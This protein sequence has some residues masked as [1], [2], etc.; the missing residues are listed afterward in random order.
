M[1]L[2]SLSY[3]LIALVLAGCASSG[4]SAAKPVPPSAAT[5]NDAQIR[6]ALVGNKLTNV[7]KPSSLSFNADGT[8]NFSG[9][10]GYSATER[11]E[12]KDGVLCISATGFATECH[13]VKAENKDFWFID[14]RSG[15]VKYQYKLTAQ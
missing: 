5:L 13:R 7:N 15:E 14:P 10:D 1:N 8:E 4:G 9:A 6:N 12:V 11:W 3:T 2:K